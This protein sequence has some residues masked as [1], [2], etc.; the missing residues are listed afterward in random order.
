[1][2]RFDPSRRAV[3]AAGL[4]LPALARAEAAAPMPIVEL[5]RYRT[6]PGR[7]D[8]LIALFEREFVETQEAV[9]MKVIGTLREPAESDRFTWLRGFSDMQARARGLNDFYFGPVWK[10]HR[11]AANACIADSDDVLLLHEAWPGSGLPPSAAPRAPAGK[12]PTS[13]P[14]L[15]VATVCYPADS[16]RFTGFFRDSMRPRMAAAGVELLG[17]FAREQSP[18]NFPRLPVREGEE[19][20]VWFTRFKDAAAREAATT[21]LTSAPGWP[22]VEAELGKR[23]ARPPYELLLQPTRRS[24]LHG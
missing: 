5:R 6:Q 21:R 19:V 10:A 20:F 18:N 14:G 1:M 15:V 2:R 24:Q 11:D 16:A 3:C 4:A 9:G 12:G 8:E 23:F 17:A 13:Q 7:R 22:V